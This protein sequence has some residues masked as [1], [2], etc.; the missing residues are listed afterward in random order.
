MIILHAAPIIWGKISGHTA[1]VPALIA[2]QNRL[3]GVE[4]ALLVTRANPEPPPQLEFPVFDRKIR[5]T[6]ADRL[7]LPVPFDRPDLVVFHSTY[8]PAHAAVVARLRKAGIPYV[9]CPRGGMTRFARAYRPW[10]KRLGNRLFFNRVVS[11]AV[12][13]HCLTPGEAEQS[14]DWHRPTFVVGN[15][16]PLPEEGQ[17]ASPGRSSPLRLVF[18]GRLAV[19]YK[20]LDM[21]IEAC[22]AI[23][24]ELLDRPA[25]LELHGPSFRG[26]GKTLARRIAVARLGEIVALNGPVLGEAKRD[27]L[28]QTDA[29]VHTSRSEG[30]PMAVL[31]ALAFGIPCLLTPGTNMA[32]EVAA[33]GAGWKAGPT[34]EGIAA[35]LREVMA[36]DENCLRQAGIKARQLAVQR[37]GWDQV[38]RG[39]VEAYRRWAA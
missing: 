21:L 32:D 20:G 11:G 28:R 38:A 37:Y 4:A 7:D 29:F 10:K 17:L 16:V 9:I 15:G 8:V 31:E 24:S 30:H 34:P 19:E 2:A 5:L 3:P 39:S 33:A 14:S 22:A 18:I 25:R 36:A 27:L 13:L 1:S 26:S 23:R 12:A 6:T 35:G